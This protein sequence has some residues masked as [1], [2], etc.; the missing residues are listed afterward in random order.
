MLIHDMTDHQCLDALDGARFGRLACARDNQPYVLPFYF[1]YTGRYLYSF[2]TLGRKIEWMRANPLVCVEVDKVISSQEWMSVIVYGRYE[3]LPDAPQWQRERELAHDLLARRA[4]WWQPSY[5]AM[6]HRGEPHS[7]TPIYYRIRMD[8]MTGHRAT[9]DEAK[10]AAI[11]H[12]SSRPALE[13]GRLYR[14]LRRLG[15]KI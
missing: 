6:T 5:V 11:P 3:E 10:V 7:L 15:A 2:A 1:A 14:I 4:M 12:T 9:P 8:D 13:H